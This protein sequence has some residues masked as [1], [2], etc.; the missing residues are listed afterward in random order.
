MKKF[1]LGLS[2]L[3]VALQHITAQDVQVNGKTFQTVKKTVL[4]TETGYYQLKEKGKRGAKQESYIKIG[5]QFHTTVFTETELKNF[6]NTG[7][8][9]SLGRREK[10]TFRDSLKI[11][12]INKGAKKIFI[13]AKGSQLNVFEYLGEVKDLFAALEDDDPRPEGE[14]KECEDGCLGRKYDE[15]EAE[16]GEGNTVCWN[17]MIYCLLRCNKEFGRLSNRL[18]SYKLT[19]N[20]VKITR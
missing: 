11:E 4:N 8:M 19:V 14:L 12:Y 16:F 7:K 17:D 9:S 10:A 3:L 13:L 5:D 20:E 6:F 15:C 1:F 18:L 2:V